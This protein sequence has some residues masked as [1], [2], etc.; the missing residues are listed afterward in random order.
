MLNIRIAIPSDCLAIQHLLVQICN[1]HH[2]GRPDIFNHDQCKYTS[3]Q[4]LALLDSPTHVIY[5]AT[6]NENVVAYIICKL[7]KS[8]PS[9]T[10][11]NIS[12]LFI[13]DLFVEDKFRNQG[14]AQKLID[15]VT[16]HAKL[17]EC[18]NVTLN[19]WNFDGSATEFYQ[20]LGF[21]TQ[22][23]TMELIL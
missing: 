23:M 17:L 14:I 9:T 21:S 7:I 15:T 19:V 6:M 10:L 18:Y 2:L 4:L 13:D 12:S 11:K 16:V 1:F 20:K 22:K 5:V 8:P 3:T